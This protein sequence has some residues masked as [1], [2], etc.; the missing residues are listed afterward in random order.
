MRTVTYEMHDLDCIELT[1]FI[2]LGFVDNLSFG[3]WIGC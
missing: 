2:S 3:Y 1:L